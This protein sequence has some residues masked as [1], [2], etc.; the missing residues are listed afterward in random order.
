MHT[1][2]GDDM[3]WDEAWENLDNQK[4]EKPTS[5]GPRVHWRESGVS[6]SAAI[7]AYTLGR[8]TYFVLE[9]LR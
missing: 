7:G 5:L 8:S 2:M 4:I 6:A 9:Y 3:D 1:T